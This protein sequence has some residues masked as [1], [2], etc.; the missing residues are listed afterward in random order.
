MNHLIETTVPPIDSI[1]MWILTRTFIKNKVYHISKN[2]ICPKPTKKLFG[3]VITVPVR[4]VSLM[5]P[6][7]GSKR[8]A[9]RCTVR[10]LGIMVPIEE[11]G[12]LSHNID[13]TGCYNMAIKECLFC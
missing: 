12:T 3:V 9:P 4:I 7:S 11:M 5:D 2:T 8:M 10:W 1:Q 6:T 13:I